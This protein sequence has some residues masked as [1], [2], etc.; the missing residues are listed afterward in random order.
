MEKMLQDDIDIL[1]ETIASGTISEKEAFK[2]KELKD[3]Q[4]K[5]WIQT[6]K[7]NK[8]FYYAYT[9]GDPAAISLARE[10]LN[11]LYRECWRLKHGFKSRK[12]FIKFLERNASK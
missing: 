8:G 11:A 5:N 7:A 3:L 6:E 2:I 9:T 1:L 10:K 4:R 12:E